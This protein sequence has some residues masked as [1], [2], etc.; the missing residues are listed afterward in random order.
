MAGEGNS[1]IVDVNRQGVE[2]LGLLAGYL[3]TLASTFPSSIVAPQNG[4][5]GVANAAGRTITLGGALAT[6]GAFTLTLTVGAN[7]SVTL[8]T[9]GT[10]ATLAGVETLTGKTLTVPKF[11][12]YTVATLPAAAAAGATARAFV[13]DANATT[14]ASVV[15]GGGANFVPVFSTGAAWL[16][17]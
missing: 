2:Y 9:A 3:S 15:A 10:L 7:T 14:F 13:T 12:S 5:T 11:T 16:I 4:G 1:Q 17:G 6:V 8:P